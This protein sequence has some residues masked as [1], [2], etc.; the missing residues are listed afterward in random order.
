MVKRIFNRKTVTFVL[1]LT[2]ICTAITYGADGETQQRANTP[3]RLGYIEGYIIEINSETIT[4]ETYEGRVYEIPLP[5]TANLQMDGHQAKRIDFKPGMEV[6]AEL[7]G[8]SIQYMDSFS[9]LN[10]GYIKPGS[11]IKTGTISSIDRNQITIKTLLGNNETYYLS[12]ATLALRKGEN[13]PL[14][15][16]YVGDRVK[17]HF[18]NITTDIVSRISIEGDSIKIKD[19]YK[20][21]I[22]AL[23]ELEN[24]LFLDN[25]KVLT[26]GKWQD[27]KGGL[28]ISYSSDFPIYIE[29]HQIPANNLKYYKGKEV[30][31]AIKDFFGQSKIERLVV[32]AAYETT[33]SEKIKDINWF[34]ENLELGNNKN[35]AFNDGTIIIKS[36]RIVDKH[37]LNPE[38]DGLFIANG[39]G[40]GLIADVVY[41]YNE[42][43][44]N[45]NIGLNNV[46]AARLDEIVEYSVKLKNP[47]LL[48]KNQWEGFEESKELYYDNDT[49]I[50]DLEEDR[51]ITSKEFYSKNYAVDEGSKY[52]R[53]HNLSDW[54]GYIYTDG[55]RISVIGVQKKLDSLLRQRT[56]I[57]TVVSAVDN[58]LVGKEL[59]IRE[60]KD[61]STR[62]EK[63]IPKEI[64]L[65]VNLDKAI[66][67]KQDKLIT[68]E[69]LKP[70]DNLY[71]IRDD[72]KAKV[73]IVK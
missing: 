10:P 2:L 3:Y 24:T 57:G 8:R 28:R 73:V 9:T 42:D 68:Y 38:S 32:K 52:A 19:L 33:Y 45:S 47:F 71:I 60:A 1:I 5:T 16:L 35:I 54:H 39:R 64:Q 12:P 4:I 53:A 59:T 61:W 23:D 7:K 15:V 29:G 50:Y 25:V 70:G 49:F 65:K 56:T 43:I 66:I 63:W 69:D 62:H 51:L 22:A 41:I 21:R 31:A 46:Y 30:Y 14:N 55:D 67:I 36:G 6:Y 27:I 37:S 58:S 44:N 26:E 40:G 17:L 18:D 20:G 72:Y 34:S 48:V 11:R 13:V